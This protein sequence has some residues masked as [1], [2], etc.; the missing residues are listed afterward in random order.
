MAFMT[1]IAPFLVICSPFIPG[2]LAFVV[3]TRTRGWLRIG[4]LSAVFVLS[5]LA[6]YNDYRCEAHAEA[7]GDIDEPCLLEAF[8][9]LAGLLSATSTFIGTVAGFVANMY[10][11]RT[12]SSPPVTGTHT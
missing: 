1:Q 8:I 11:L 9:A 6:M 2:F 7:V 10:R 3:V 12:K 4:L 5:A